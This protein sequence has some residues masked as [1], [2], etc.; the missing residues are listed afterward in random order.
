MS[1]HL[2]GV[3]GDLPIGRPPVPILPPPQ[4]EHVL[5][6][7]AEEMEGPHV[8]LCDLQ[9]FTGFYWFL[10][11]STGFYWFLLDYTG[12]QRFTQVYIGEVLT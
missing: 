5:R 9:V 8:V 11:V 4:V 7:A 12:L 10:L 6:E 1:R 2:P 3:L